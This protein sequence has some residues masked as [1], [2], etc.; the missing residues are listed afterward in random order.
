MY[1]WAKASIF[2]GFFLM[3]G[4]SNW[5]IAKKKEKKNLGGTLFNY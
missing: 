3:M 1:S 2:F 4:Q 5:L